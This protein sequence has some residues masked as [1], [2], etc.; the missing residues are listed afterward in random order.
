MLD[1]KLHERFLMILLRD[2]YSDIYLAPR[3]LF[4][5][6]T[7]CYF[8]YKL[9]RFSTDLDFD[10]L[11]KQSAS[12]VKDRIEK[13]IQKYGR[14]TDQ[15]IKYNTIFFCFA[16]R[17]GEQNIKLEISTR[18]L[19]AGK[20]VKNFFGLSVP[21]M[22]IEDMF[23]YKLIAITGRKKIANRDLYDTNWFFGQQI[24]PNEEII[25]NMTNMDTVSYLKKVLLFVKKN[26]GNR[27]ILNGLGEVL[28]TDQKQW[29]KQ[30]LKD[31]LIFH[32]ETYII[33]YKR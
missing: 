27:N 8:F 26:I 28:D 6:G 12:A 23:S 10:L 7:A 1:Q 15:Q 19:P 25:Q 5:G 13:I 24:V 2:I 33:S 3:L 29:V 32:L 21:V 14:I 4:K 16:Y 20:T 22:N 11:E 17:V 9:N 31:N 18:D 30:N